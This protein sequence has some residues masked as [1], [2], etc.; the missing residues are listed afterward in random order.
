MTCACVFDCVSAGS[1]GIPP[2][3]IRAYGSIFG[4]SEGG[5]F[6]RKI[7]HTI[8]MGLRGGEI[9]KPVYRGL[10]CINLAE[11]VW[12]TPCACSGAKHRSR[13]RPRAVRDQSTILSSCLISIDLGLFFDSRLNAEGA[14]A[15]RRQV[16]RNKVRR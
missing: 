2:L 4:R 11:I 5:Q 15:D 14:Y 16:C 1:C 8:L 10:Y 6:N 13:T 3:E 7:S 12:Q 9:S